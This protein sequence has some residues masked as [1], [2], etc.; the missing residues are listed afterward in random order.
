[1]EPITETYIDKSDWY[2]G[3]WDNEPD[4]VEWRCEGTPR[5]PCLIV[6]G[7]H[8]ALCGYVGVPP[9]HP[10]HGIRDTDAYRL[11]LDV[12][13]G[14]TYGAPCQEDGKI[15]HVPRPGE[16]PDV[17]WLGFDCAHYG[18]YSHMQSR[19]FEN[20]PDPETRRLLACPPSSFESYRSVRYVRAQVEHLARQ[21]QR[22][23]KGLPPTDEN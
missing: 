1:M 22:V 14:I 3:P 19:Q 4:R 20:H 10:Y 9:G 12:H 2:R 15:C 5:L 7:P 21:L 6:R 23:A 16:S 11:D 17:M 8:G 13:G 18:D